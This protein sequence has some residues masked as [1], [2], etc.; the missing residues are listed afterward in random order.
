MLVSPG[1][2][3]LTAPNPSLM[4]GSGTNT[5]I[6]GYG[7]LAVIDPGPE[8]ERH[9]DAIQQ[10]IVE[11]G[12]QL[13]LI[14]VTHSHVDHLPGAFILQR[15]G[16]GVPI[17]ACSQTL[18]IDVALRDGQDVSVGGFALRALHTPGH[19]QDHLCFHLPDLAE[20]FS[21]DLIAG[22]GTVVIGRDGEL[23]HY[24]N[25]LAGLLP[26]RLRRIY[27]GHGPI[28]EQPRERI[29]EYIAHRHARER[30]L[31]EALSAGPLMVMEMVRAV[32]VDV[33]ERLY[34]VAAQTVEA[35][36]RKLIRDGAVVVETGETGKRYALS[37]A[38]A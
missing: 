1:I 20:L 35:H 18:G 14:L 16:G 17:A 38:N 25:S 30:A 36:L 8:D 15:R 31:L 32:Y 12:G 23:E 2:R 9:I 4:T 28:V 24:L 19:A 34:P 7:D 11:A 5:Y 29:D 26:L 13:V 37:R 33:D 6:V 27:P 3:R 22:E 21:G 10:A